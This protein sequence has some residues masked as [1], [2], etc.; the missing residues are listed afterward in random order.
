[1]PHTRRFVFLALAAGIVALA[2]AFTVRGK[3]ATSATTQT[4]RIEVRQVDGPSLAGNALEVPATRRV[5]VYLPP[6]YD[7]SPRRAY[8][9][10]YVLHGIF[11]SDTTWTSPWSSSPPGY[12]TIQALMNRGVAAGALEEMIIVIPDSEKTCHYTNSPL[13]GNWEDFIRRDLVAFI[14]GEYRTLARPASRGIAGH[15]MG[16]HGAIKLGMKYPDT[17]SAVYGLNPSLL[18]WGGDLSVDNPALAGL[19]TLESLAD[20]GS[21]HFYVQALAGVGHCF[22]PSP[23]DPPFLTDFPFEVVDGQVVRAAP[24]A[25]RW[26]AQMPLYMIDTYAENLSRLRGLRFDTALVEEFSHIPLTSK[27]FSD[28]LT[29]RG[30]AHQ[31][32]MY[33]GDHRNRLWGA[34]GRLYTELLPYFS[35]LLET[36]G[37]G[38]GAGYDRYLESSASRRSMQESSSSRLSGFGKNSATPDRKALAT[39]SSVATPDIAQTTG[40]WVG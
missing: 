23:S 30:I 7:T 11:D 22:S 17:F 13:K 26:E 4:G 24:G 36:D 2:G 34:Q 33:N 8:P 5:S 28:A 10:L 21:A 39:S 1:M 12:D 20:L 37:E 6:S 19:A 25:E 18:G 29:Q 14:D 32:E 27:A 35:S 15:S 3:P 40:T 38:R 16:G 31:F 9:T